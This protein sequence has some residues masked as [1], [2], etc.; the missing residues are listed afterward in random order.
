[1]NK[2][3]VLQIWDHIRQVNGI[4]LRLIEALPENKLDTTVI[5]NMRTPKE[6]A[7]HMYGQVLREVAEGTVRGTITDETEKHEKQIAAGLKTKADLMRYCLDCWNA[8]DSAVRALPEDRVMGMTATPWGRSFPGFVS[9]MLMS[10]EYI[11]HRGQLYAYLRA[12][13]VAPPH[14][15]SF[16]ENAGAFRPEVA[17][18]T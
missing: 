15:W 7:V 1:M 13:G 16:G 12:L 4:G 8:A 11:H 9:F 10:D 2:Q 6:L 17:A 14:M 5:P 18:T 3:A